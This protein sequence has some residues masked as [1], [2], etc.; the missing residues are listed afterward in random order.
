MA[1]EQIIKMIEEFGEVSV[2]RYD[3]LK[4]ENANIR[5][6]FIQI[7][8]K[9]GQMLT[10][11]QTTNDLKDGIGSCI[12]TPANFDGLKSFIAGGKTRL[13]LEVKDMS[14]AN[15]TGGT[16]SITAAPYG[17]VGA[18]NRF[19]HVRD[20]LPKINMEN[21]TLPIIR[22]NGA[23]GT[24]T[25]VAEGG[26]KPTI[27]FNLAE[28]PAKAEVIA[29]IVN[30]TRQFLDDLGPHGVM[31]WLQSRLT[32]LY[33]IAEDDQLLNGNGIS[34][35][36]GGVNL[37]GNFTA[38]TSL[39]AVNDVEQLIRS[40]LQMRTLQRRPTAVVIHP[41]DLPDL[42]LNVSAGSGEYDLPSYVRVNDLG[43]LSILGV[44]VIDTPAQT[45]GRFNILDTNQMLMGI[46][47]NFKIE[48]FEQD[49]SNVRTNRITV[50]AEARVAFA[51]YGAANTIQGT[52]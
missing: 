26:T 13:Q 15:L 14:I 1:Q 31:N 50:R 38:A 42:L 2:K 7:K 35:N 44:P 21:G 19:F 10:F 43:G 39:A 20:V 41:D 45:T 40:L 34:P 36:L 49:G 46:R 5:D 25:P 37:A 8:K 32:E 11:G 17:I 27:D 6:E 16:A 4:A 48:F 29:A 30:V 9:Q 23:T 22:D 52:F 18:I 3:D 33:L 28:S 24:F 47:E 12:N 51:T